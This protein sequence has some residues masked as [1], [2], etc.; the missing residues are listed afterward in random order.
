MITIICKLPFMVLRISISWVRR[1]QVAHR[2]WSFPNSC[3]PQNLAEGAAKI[4]SYTASRIIFRHGMTSRRYGQRNRP[5]YGYDPSLNSGRGPGP[6]QDG[7][8]NHGDNYTV[9]HGGYS[10]HGIDAYY[11][12]YDTAHGY[13][14]NRDAYRT[15]SYDY[16]SYSEQ[17]YPSDTYQEYYQE[18]FYPESYSVE[19]DGPYQSSSRGHG[20]AQMTYA[21]Q[22]FDDH[23]SHTRAPSS[24]HNHIQS[25]NIH[26]NHT[27]M[28]NTG[29]RS[30]KRRLHSPPPAPPRPPSP[31]YLSLANEEPEQLSTSSDRRKLL[32]LDLNGTLVFRSVWR[33]KTKHQH[34]P[35]S[36]SAAGDPGDAGSAPPP[37]RLR[38]AHPRPYLPAFR[39]YLFA[40]ETQRW[41]DVMVWSSAQPHSV[42]GM[43][44]RVFG[45]EA[46]AEGIANGVPGSSRAGGRSADGVTGGSELEDGEE[47]KA[48]KP[49]LVAIWARD[50]LGLS[51]SNYR[52]SNPLKT[53]Y[54]IYSHL[55]TLFDIPFPLLCRR[56]FSHLAT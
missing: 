56:L 1:I 36:A 29:E 43:V 12:T 54:L 46:Y 52:T 7:Y 53:C 39:D 4:R 14:D 11:G 10:S 32:I 42:Q 41:L 24:S 28:S 3:Y 22:G 37:P 35:P 27:P 31:S 25:R 20:E 21:R 50:T 19:H 30:P 45:Q 51:N 2:P 26:H 33:G 18:S 16:S 48:S 47:K 49:R 17:Y 40:P 44:E 23:L 8:Q 13:S 15:A 38:T 5:N 34:A 6:W 9:S 55:I